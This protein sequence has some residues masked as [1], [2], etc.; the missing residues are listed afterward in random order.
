MGILGDFRISRIKKGINII[1]ADSFNRYL[2]VIVRM[3]I[4]EILGLVGL[5]KESTFYLQ[6]L[7]IDI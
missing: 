1:F 5:K 6:I 3:G 4:L 7:L 2:A